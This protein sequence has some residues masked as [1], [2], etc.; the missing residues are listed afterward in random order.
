MSQDNQQVVVVNFDSSLVVVAKEDRL[1]VIAVRQYDN[2]MIIRIR[3]KVSIM[4]LKNHF[5]FVEKV[6]TAYKVRSMALMSVGIS[7]SE[8]KQSEFCTIVQFS[9]VD[10]QVVESDIKAK[11]QKF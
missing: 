5:Q 9:L 7:N 4:S 3:I 6:S 2:R 11:L 1:Q 10:E 8:V